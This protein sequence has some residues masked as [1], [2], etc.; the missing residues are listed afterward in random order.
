M[1]Q[2]T[3]P[4]FN[5]SCGL[6]HLPSPPESYKAI[7][8][9]TFPIAGL[10]FLLRNIISLQ[11][12]GLHELI[13]YIETSQEEI[14]TLALAIKKDSRVIAKT[15]WASNPKQLKENLNNRKN[16]VLIFNGSNLYDKKIV[17]STLKTFIQQEASTSKALSI[18]K[19]ELE[20]LIAII[21]RNNA[22]DL[23]D[24]QDRIPS[25]K[26]ISASAT[27]NVKVQEDF[28]I[29]HERLLAGSGQN[30]DSP[31]TRLL[32][33]PVSQKM[34]RLFLNTTISPNQITLFSFAMGLGSA[35]CFTEG[36]YL[37]NILGG[38]F[39]LFSTWVDGADGE[40]ARLKFMET[41]IG[42]K[43][44]IICDNI[45]HFFVFGA[46]GWGAS[47]ATGEV[48]YLYLGGLAAVASLAS[49]ILLGA[50]ILKKNTGATS[51]EPNSEPSMAEKLANRDFIHFLMLMALIDQ[52]KVFIVVAA[53]G[54]SIFTIY[55]IYIRL[56]QESK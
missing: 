44:D 54:A 56:T 31:I 12:S 36:T 10:P 39:L 19:D 30:H 28:N 45:V 5:L 21:R 27:A 46:I 23:T 40:I 6:L 17:C 14:D 49:F 53:I 4:S 29:Q 34:T 52:V 55:M 51:P 24:I 20:A 33:R 32:S 42:G 11:R 3:N 26:Y 8:W 35:I 47:K 48:I 1:N 18:S 50:I 9:Y 13:I 43:L 38:L 41:E 2:N 15:Q 22:N 16:K 25:F 7:D 37:M